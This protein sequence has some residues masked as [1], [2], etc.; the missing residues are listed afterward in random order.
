MFEDLAAGC[1]DEL[2]GCDHAAVAL[3]AH[4]AEHAVLA[5][6]EALQLAVESRQVE[7]E[8][9]R[10]GHCFRHTTAPAKKHK[11]RESEL[12]NDATFPRAAQKYGRRLPGPGRRDARAFLLASPAVSLL[13]VVFE[14]LLIFQKSECAVDF[15]V[16]DSTF[17]H[18]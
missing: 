7:V 6:D 1:E 10:G 12:T 14:R 11:I 2:V 9:R 8:R 3:D 4:V 17:D 16:S 13:E 18:Y 15:S 5:R